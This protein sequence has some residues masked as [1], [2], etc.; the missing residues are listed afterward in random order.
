[1]LKEQDA[2]LSVGTLV[3]ITNVLTLTA[4][5]LKNENNMATEVMD[6]H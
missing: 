1:M 2:T 4:S 3:V 6:S 5:S